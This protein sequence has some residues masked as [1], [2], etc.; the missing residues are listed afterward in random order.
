VNTKTC[1]LRINENKEKIDLNTVLEN[2]ET[3]MRM[4]VARDSECLILN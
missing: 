2:C 4:K 3:T 1:W